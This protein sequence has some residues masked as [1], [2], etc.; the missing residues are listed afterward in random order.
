MWESRKILRGWAKL[1]GSAAG[2]RT[3]SNW[4]VATHSTIPIALSG[5]Q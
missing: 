3:S 1:D 5:I 2:L 4:N